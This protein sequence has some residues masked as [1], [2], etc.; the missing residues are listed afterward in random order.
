MNK[1]NTDFTLLLEALSSLKTGQLG[2]KNTGDK[3]KDEN[4]YENFVKK[5]I[6]MPVLSGLLCIKRTPLL[7]I[8][9]R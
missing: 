3:K 7:L 5:Y 4:I 9:S 2:T 6:Y 1:S 8:F